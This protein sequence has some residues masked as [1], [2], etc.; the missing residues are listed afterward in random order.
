MLLY[1]SSIFPQ[2]ATKYEEEDLAIQKR[3]RS[4][5]WINSQHLDS[6]INVTSLEVRQLVY[7]AIT[8]LLTVDS[9]KTPN[10]KLEFIGKCSSQIRT[11]ILKIQEAPI[12]ADQFL[13]ALIF[14]VLKANPVRP[15]SNIKYIQKMCN[16]SRVMKGENSYLFT[17]LVGF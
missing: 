8:F 13:P 9:L 7:L 14:V 3:I 15:I 2:F 1:F 11:M 12:G 10:T 4:L 16:E 5:N 17:S 6:A